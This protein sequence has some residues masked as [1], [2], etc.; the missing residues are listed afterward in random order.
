MFTFKGSFSSFSV[1]DIAEA[2]RFY[3]ETL[4]LNVKESPEGLELHFDDGHTVFLY[5][6]PHPAALYTVLNFIVDDIDKAVDDLVAHGVTM[7]QYDMSEIKTDKRG[8][9]RNDNG[10]MGPKAI[11]WFKD[12]F[13]HIIAVMQEK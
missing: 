13:G 1:P 2:K 12:P 10:E 5:P 8:I 11:G 3:K 9:C 6:A 4:G 7:E